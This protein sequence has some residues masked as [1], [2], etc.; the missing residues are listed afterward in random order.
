MKKLTDEIFVC[1]NCPTWA[2]Y[3]AVDKNGIAYWYTEEPV[4]N[5]KNGAGLLII[6]ASIMKKFL[7]KNMIVQ[8]G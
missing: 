4:C 5:I 8:I 3:A 2:N 6:T 1:D 7:M